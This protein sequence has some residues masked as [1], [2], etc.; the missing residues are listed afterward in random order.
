MAQL[1][2]PHPT[3]RHPATDIWIWLLNGATVIGVL[4]SLWLALW[5]TPKEAVEGDVFRIFYVHVPLAWNMYVAFFV[6]FAASVLYLWRREQVWDR[7]ARVSAEVGLLF[8]TLVLITGSIWGRPVW[9]VWWTWD[10]RLTTT[11]VLWF[12]YLAYL[13]LRSYSRDG[14]Q[15][16][17]YAAVLGI[18]AF[19]DVPIVQFSVTWWRTLHPQSDILAP[20][21]LAGSMVAGML[22]SLV[23]FSLLGLAL[24]VQRYRIESMRDEARTLR[25]RLEEAEG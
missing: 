17:R 4:V 6:V 13:L 24:F 10:A 9:G 15:A 3:N 21:H 7:V 19:V 25:Q 20:G 23:S 16:P 1:V 5:W 11:L 2:V 8:T 12:M 18:V 14:G 22:V